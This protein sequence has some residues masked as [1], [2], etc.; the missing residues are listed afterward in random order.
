M[1]SFAN[2]HS[3]WLDPPEE[4]EAVFC[5]DCGEEMEVSQDMSGEYRAICFYQWCPSRFEGDAREMA[6]LLIGATETIK[7]LAA[8][9]KRLEN[10]I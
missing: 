2:A 7:S 5:D 8:K 10:K 4:P 9:V 6:E 3:R 1:N